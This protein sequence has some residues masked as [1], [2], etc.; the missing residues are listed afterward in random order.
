MSS[1]NAVRPVEASTTQ[2]TRARTYAYAAMM[3]FRWTSLKKSLRASITSLGSR[4]V[5]R[6][7]ERDPFVRKTKPLTRRGSESLDEWPTWRH[8]GGARSNGCDFR[9]PTVKDAIP[10]CFS[11]DSLLVPLALR[12][13][14]GA[15]NGGLSLASAYRGIG[16]ET[17]RRPVVITGRDPNKV[18]AG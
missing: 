2:S 10:Y 16:S 15:D 5:T 18:M 8:A 1:E 12:P 9:P 3:W 11:T 13:V 6:R 14:S 4:A 17:V 7:K